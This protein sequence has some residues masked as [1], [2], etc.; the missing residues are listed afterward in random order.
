MWRMRNKLVLCSVAAAIGLSAPTAS[1]DMV[2]DYLAKVPAG[3]ISCEQATKYY[4]N[5]SDYNS[6]K[7]Q[8]LAA[9]NFHPRGPEIRDAV[10]RADEAIA[11]CGLNGGGGNTAPAQN[12]A[13]ANN[14]V[15]AN[16]GGG[17]PANNGN[18]APSNNA[19]PTFPVTIG[20]FTFN[21]PDILAYLKTLVEGTPLA[22][23]LP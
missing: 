3:Q 22:Q 12:T 23:L 15:P 7:S 2:D 19:F 17:A 4:T 14:T 6:K 11:R 20:N 18:N 9:A 21:V 10:A 16:N 8:A 13:P 1:A 5:P